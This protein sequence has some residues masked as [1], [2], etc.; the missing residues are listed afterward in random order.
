VAYKLFTNCRPDG[1]VGL[2]H[3]I[4][5]ILWLARSSVR[6]DYGDLGIKL[7]LIAWRAAA[8]TPHNASFVL[9][10]GIIGLLIAL[11]VYVAVRSEGERPPSLKGALC[12]MAVGVAIFALGYAIFCT[13]GQILFFPTGISNRVAIAAALGV[14]TTF[15]GGIWF[16]S[17]LVRTA[18]ARTVAFSLITASLCVMGFVINNTLAAYWVQAWQVEQA[19]LAHIHDDVP[20]LP[21]NSTLLL[22][23]VCPY[24]GPGIVF[25]SNWDL[26]GALY[27]ARKDWT[28][29]ADVVTPAL[30]YDDSGVTAFLYG[31]GTHYSY[32][33]LYVYDV[34]RRSVRQL[35]DEASARTYFEQV[36]TNH[37]GG[38]PSGQA[39]CG[40]PVL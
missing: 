4:A 21:K 12:V 26:A 15:V 14:A 40:V 17:A 27:L 2:R 19:V 32:D 37:N 9:V 39:G 22:D 6:Q 33:H 31:A 10:A 38:C 13:T 29:K 5:H 18:T 25:E 11:Y 8:Y 35:K 34:G 1:L 36:S 30:T 24:V 3:R 23:G 20:P 28:L 7:P 16:V